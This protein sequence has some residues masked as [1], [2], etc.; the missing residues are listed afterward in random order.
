MHRALLA[1]A[2]AATA[3]GSRARAESP[4]LEEIAAWAHDGGWRVSAASCDDVEQKSFGAVAAACWFAKRRAPEAGT[5]DLYPR[6][7]IV[8]AVYRDEEAA[9]ARMARFREIP[10]D[11]RG[12]EQLIYPLRAGFRVGNRVVLVMTDAVRFQDEAYRAALALAAR[13]GGLDVTCWL[14]CP[15]G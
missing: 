1:L 14:R 2:I 13:A 7:D 5:T 11:L 8:V 12:E 9:R 4:K 15:A 10:D 6:V 3:C